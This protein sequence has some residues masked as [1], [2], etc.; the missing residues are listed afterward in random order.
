M[1]DTVFGGAYKLKLRSLGFGRFRN[2]GVRGNVRDR[3]RYAH[4]QT[5]KLFFQRAEDWKHP[6]I[7]GICQAVS[8]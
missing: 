4:V 8:H 7:F 1:R 6:C 3:R 5:G 2:W